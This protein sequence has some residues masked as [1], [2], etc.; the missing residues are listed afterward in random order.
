MLAVTDSFTK[1][2]EE[3]REKQKHII[4]IQK[5]SYYIL[6]QS[7]N[8][9]TNRNAFIS[10]RAHFVTMISLSFKKHTSTLKCN[11]LYQQRLALST[12]TFSQSSE[13]PGSEE[14]AE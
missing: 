2:Q 3:E 9:N 1:R 7:I 11:F 10:L 8:T 13:S 12:E 6:R 14:P 4:S 5:K